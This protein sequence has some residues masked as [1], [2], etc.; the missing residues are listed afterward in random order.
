M[1]TLLLDL[2]VL[3]TLSCPTNGVVGRKHQHRRFVSSLAFLQHV[4]TVGH[5]SELQRLQLY[6]SGRS[7]K[8]PHLKAD[9]ADRLVHLAVLVD[10]RLR[11]S[12]FNRLTR[13]FARSEPQS[14]M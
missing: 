10:V 1:I 12:T 7:C 4:S 6:Q 3:Q 2:G 13:A 11:Y 8:K 5:N 14:V 9:L